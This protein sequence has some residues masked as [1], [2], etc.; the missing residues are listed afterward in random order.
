MEFYDADRFRR[1]AVVCREKSDKARS[2]VDAA[3]WRRL[4]NDFEKLAGREADHK[5]RTAHAEL[6]DCVALIWMVICEIVVS[7]QVSNR[8]S[9]SL[10]FGFGGIWR[11]QGL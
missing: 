10:V 3:S 8:L 4:V 9:G 6:P 11:L 1:L 7:E 2:L 5:A